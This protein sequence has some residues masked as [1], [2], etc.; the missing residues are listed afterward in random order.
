LRWIA[1]ATVRVGRLC[2]NTPEL[3]DERVVF[4]SE[5]VVKK[6]EADRPIV[7]KG[8]RF[9]ACPFGID[10]VIRPEDR[11][12][13]RPRLAGSGNQQQLCHIGWI[14]LHPLA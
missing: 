11:Q 13:P 6:T 7:W 3:G 12:I 9:L 10:G 5:Q 14:A 2:R 1:K 4:A 8:R